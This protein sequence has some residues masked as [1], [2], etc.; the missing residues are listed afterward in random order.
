MSAKE[1]TS[2][3]RDLLV[4]A[5]ILAP[6][7][8][9][10]QPWLFRFQHTVEIYRDPRRELLAEDPDGRMTM[11]GVGAA[12]F[13]VRV[14]VAGMGRRSSTVLVRDPDRPTLA[15]EV[16]IGPLTA[17]RVEPAH[18]FGFLARRRTSRYPFASHPIPLQVRQE[19]LDAA[20]HEGAYLDWVD[21]RDRCR[22]LLEVASDADAA[23]TQDPDRL[24]ERRAW[25][26]GERGS[27]GVPSTAL[28]PRPAEPSAPV[29]DLAV[30]PFDRRRATQQF[31]LQPMLAVLSTERD[32]WQDWLTAGQALQRVLLVA[33][34]HE[35]AVSLLNQPLE[36]AELRSQIRDPHSRWSEP[37]AILRFGYGP[38]VL[39]PPRRPAAD[40]L[41]DEE[42]TPLRGRG[43]Q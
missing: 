3:E 23:D 7:M 39:P 40:F 25:V 27:A 20:E 13:N 42:T 12:T 15:A 41:F 33:T 19:L 16:R 1:L 4:K 35:L 5:A 31:E 2:T 34:T 30:D 22:W 17:G 6:S 28:G 14:A 11:I 24:A 32:S 43:D 9:N 21:D 36:H 8:H 37:Q 38:T 10:T 26:G 29:R 18:L